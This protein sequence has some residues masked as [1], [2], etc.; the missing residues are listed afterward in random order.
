[1][2]P[3]SAPLARMTRSLPPP[4]RWLRMRPASL[5]RAIVR[6]S[7]AHACATSPVVT[8]SIDRPG[9]SGRTDIGP[10]SH[11]RRPAVNGVNR[12]EVHRG[13]ARAGGGFTVVVGRLRSQFK[14]VGEALGG[15]RAS[16]HKTLS[17]RRRDQQGPEIATRPLKERARRCRCT[18]GWSPSA[19][20]LECRS[21]R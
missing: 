18:S 5:H 13:R 2:T 7:T 17:G 12:T 9:I 3:P 16:I 20:D 15:L 19:F 1:L 11:G 6:G 14:I 4:V 10:P 8:Q 21:C